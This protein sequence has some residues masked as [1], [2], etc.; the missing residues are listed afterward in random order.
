MLLRT[1]LPLLKEFTSLTAL[2]IRECLIVVQVINDK[3][4]IF[5]LASHLPVIN[6]HSHLLTRLAEQLLIVLGCRN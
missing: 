3:K 4:E 2:E 6:Q 1:R 5:L